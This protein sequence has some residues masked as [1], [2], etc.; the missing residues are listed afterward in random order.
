MATVDSTWH[1]SRPLLQKKKIQKQNKKNSIPSFPLLPSKG[2]PKAIHRTF[3]TGSD[4]K[5]SRGTR[6]NQ[7]MALCSGTLFF[8]A[9]LKSFGDKLTMNWEGKKKKN[10][11]LE[12]NSQLLKLPD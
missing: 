9:I 4:P 7:W 1:L 5:E 12:K 10:S 2:L 3:F 6:F 8:L 11:L